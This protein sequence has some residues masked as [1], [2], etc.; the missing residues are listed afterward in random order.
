M[1]QMERRRKGKEKDTK[2][3]IELQRHRSSVVATASPVTGLLPG[4][5]EEDNAKDENE[6]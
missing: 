4:H 1:N 6:K 2:Q 5:E 3:Q